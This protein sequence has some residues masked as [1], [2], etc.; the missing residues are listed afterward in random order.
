M[1]HKIY[2]QTLFLNIQIKKKNKSKYANI[3][4]RFPYCLSLWVNNILRVHQ[5]LTSLYT[6]FFWNRVDKWRTQVGS[7]TWLLSSFVA[8]F[9]VHLKDSGSTHCV[10]AFLYPLYSPRIKHRRHGMVVLY[11]NEI[12]L[13]DWCILFQYV[14][15]TEIT[16]RKWHYH[17]PSEFTTQN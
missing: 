11:T 10:S 16:I 3:L 17:K 12:P 7:V 14:I 4:K 8:L 1:I 9:W 15:S 13:S 6:L 5:I 2:F